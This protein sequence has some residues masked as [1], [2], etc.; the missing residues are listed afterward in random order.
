MAM[1]QIY[2]VQVNVFDNQDVVPHPRELKANQDPDLITAG[3][4]DYLYQEFPKRFVWHTGQA[5]W[6]VH[7]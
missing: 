7:Q 3:V 2:F 4:H 6:K 5:V 1:H